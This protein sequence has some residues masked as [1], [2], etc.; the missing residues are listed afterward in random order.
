MGEP[1]CGFIRGQDEC[2][3]PATHFYRRRDLPHMQIRCDVH[4]S[5]VSPKSNWM[6]QRISKEEYL[7]ALILES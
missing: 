2:D 3:L 7:I 5:K 4:E 6:W 1:L